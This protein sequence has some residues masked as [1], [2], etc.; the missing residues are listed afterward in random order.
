MHQPFVP[1][2]DAANMC[3]ATG[4]DSSNTAGSKKEITWQAEETADKSQSF[5]GLFIDICRFIIFL[6]CH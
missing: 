2:G 5:S 1:Q 6:L 4:D 3:D